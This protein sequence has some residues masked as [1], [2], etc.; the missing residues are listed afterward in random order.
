[1]GKK[2]QWKHTAATKDK[3]VVSSALKIP[4]IVSSDKVRVVLANRKRNS[5]SRQAQDQGLRHA[6]AI[7]VQ[8]ALR[9]TWT[10]NTKLMPPEQDG[11]GGWKPGPHPRVNTEALIGA[12]SGPTDPALSA[13]STER[14]FLATQIKAADMKIIMGYTADAI[15]ANVAAK[16]EAG[17]QLAGKKPSDES[18]DKAIKPDHLRTHSEVF[19]LWL[20]ARIKTAQLPAG[21]PQKRLWDKLDF[22]LPYTVYV[23]LNKF[24]TFAISIVD[25]E[26]TEEAGAQDEAEV[27]EVEP[28]CNGGYVRFSVDHESCVGVGARAPQLIYTCAGNETPSMAA[29]ELNVPIATLLKD[30]QAGLPGLRGNSKLK[31]GT[32]LSAGT[33]GSAGVDE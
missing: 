17:W 9:H 25:D 6:V 28:E 18:V 3:P 31:A 14:E 7:Y 15:E 30:N 33:C 10:G 29:K 27:V 13:T 5:S 16:F 12:T 21:I 22:C 26:I 20:A 11:D 23:A 2:K 8:K 24:L 1:M 19:Q 4:T 32:E